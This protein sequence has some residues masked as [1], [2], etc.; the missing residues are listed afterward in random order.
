MATKKAAKKAA[1]K[2]TTLKKAKPSTPVF[3]P[4]AYTLAADKAIALNPKV[5]GRAAAIAVIETLLENA[6]GAASIVKFLKA[7]LAL[8][9][10]GKGED[11]GD[12]VAD[13][14]FVGPRAK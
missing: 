14:I 9:K 13:P 1:P 4:S 8:T 12:P 5:K 2:K 11:G 10:G 6:S 7:A 3:K